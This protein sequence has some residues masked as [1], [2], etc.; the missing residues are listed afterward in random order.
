[1]RRNLR[2]SLAANSPTPSAMLSAI[3]SAAALELVLAMSIAFGEL[4]DDVVDFFNEFKCG[5]VHIEF[6]ELKVHLVSSDVS[7]E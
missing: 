5:L 3:E 7:S 4:T 6:F 1:M 2:R